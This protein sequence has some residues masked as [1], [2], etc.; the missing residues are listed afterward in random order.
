MEKVPAV[1]IPYYNFAQDGQI[2]EGDRVVIPNILRNQMEEN[3]HGGRGVE[4]TCLR[5]AREALEWPGMI[6]ESKQKRDSD[7]T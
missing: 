3:I 2:F 1:L 5:R 7:T 4:Q 6:S